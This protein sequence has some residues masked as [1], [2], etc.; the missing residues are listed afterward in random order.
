MQILDTAPDQVVTEFG[1][2]R[3]GQQFL[4]P[5]ARCRGEGVIELAVNPGAAAPGKAF[6]PLP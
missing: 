1:R 2:H 6:G 4:A 3:D 5:V